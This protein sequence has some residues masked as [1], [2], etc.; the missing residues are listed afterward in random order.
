[1][2]ALR[3]HLRSVSVLALLAPL[4]S[5]G[6]G[7]AM[8]RQQGS[9][10]WILAPA[11]ALL[12]G[13]AT[14]V[15]LRKIRRGL[16]TIDRDLDRLAPGDRIPSPGSTLDGRVAAV[17]EALRGQQQ[18][19]ERHQQLL[20]DLMDEAPM[21]ILLLEDAGAIEY[22][23]QHA[24]ALFFEGRAVA[25]VNFLAL[26]GDAPAAFREAVLS[27]QDRLFTVNA[28]GST[29]TYHLAK[30][31]VELAGKTHTLLL[32]KHLT[33][34]LRQR[35]IETWKK[36]IRVVSHELNN[37]LAP[38]TSMVHSARI[39]TAAQATPKLERVFSTIEERAQHLQSFVEG[40][41]RYAR[42]PKPRRDPVNLRDFASHLQ[43]VAPHA[44]IAT[45]EGDTSFDRSQM[46]QVLINLIKNAT[47]A[48]GSQEAVSV[49]MACAPDGALTISVS[50]RGPGMSPEVMQ[51]ATLPFFSTKAGGTGLGLA[52]CREI[53]EGHGGSLSLANRDGGGLVVTCVL[54]GRERPAPRPQARLT[55]S[56]V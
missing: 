39:M 25:G 50:D 38:I 47:E 35:E 51:N 45:R 24:R 48:G 56:R 37:S 28:G 11:L 42:L 26:L 44:R 36:L 12:L 6:A 33:F 34:E 13:A 3:T 19:A 41:A 1:M 32:V 40:Y 43:N 17:G 2:A 5:A 20:H 27:D 14:V 15:P 21:A 54:P 55:L 53:V 7:V 30:R 49:E 46:E 52:L 22:A 23:N 8:A 18:L 31:N 16:Q 29:E 9:A 10:A 4:V